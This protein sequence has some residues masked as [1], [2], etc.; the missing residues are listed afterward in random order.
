MDKSFD[1][2]EIY[3]LRNIFT[4]PDDL[5]NYM[6]LGHYEVCSINF[7]RWRMAIRFWRY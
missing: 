1:K 3:V 2:F 5:V 6:R 7:E 4:V